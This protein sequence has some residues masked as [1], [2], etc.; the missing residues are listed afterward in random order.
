ME[1]STRSFLNVL[2][3]HHVAEIIIDDD[4]GTQSYVCKIDKIRST[5]KDDRLYKFVKPLKSLK[6]D[7]L[8]MSDSIEW[9]GVANAVEVYK[10]PS[11]MMWPTMYCSKQKKVSFIFSEFL[12]RRMNNLHRHR[13]IATMN[14]LWY[15]PEKINLFSDEKVVWAGSPGCGKTIAV[16][17]IIL[18]CVI[19][20]NEIG[21]ENK[22]TT[23]NQF[24][25][26]NNDFLTRFYYDL[27]GNKVDF[28]ILSF[29]SLHKLKKYL[30][31]EFAFNRNSFVLYEMDEAEVDPMIEMPFLLSTSC[32]NLRETIKTTWKSQN[33]FYLYDPMLYFEFEFFV[34]VSSAFGDR[35]PRA[36]ITDLLARFPLS[37]GIIRNIFDPVFTSPVSA[38]FE[39][40]AKHLTVFTLLDDCNP[41]NIIPLV[42]SIVGVKFRLPLQPVDEDE[43]FLAFKL[44]SLYNSSFY[45]IDSALFEFC[46]FRKNWHVQYLSDEIAIEIGKKLCLPSE[47]QYSNS[48]ALYQVQEIINI[49]G[50]ILKKSNKNI[51]LPDS[52]YMKNWEF[53]SCSMVPSSKNLI[54]SHKSVKIELSSAFLRS[55]NNYLISMMPTTTKI[56]TFQGQYL[57]TPFKKLQPSYVY[58]ASVHN[59]PVFDALTA[60]PVAGR[61]FLF[62][63]TL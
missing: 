33:T 36:T 20:L 21:K 50:G 18:D 57:Q 37:G 35:L 45:P 10:L 4:Y 63:S 11:S 16:N 43:D 47:I 60:D 26:R 34:N 27:K 6:A 14:R 15:A 59:G 58:H 30:N 29:E 5:L 9:A 19:K 39:N 1:S 53:F 12:I 55:D 54:Y 31:N 7:E 8:P 42:N 38:V 2:L 3:A 28:E 46:H 62:Q 48:S 44:S 51:N 32:R 52:F 13:V 25:F 61:L 49:Y 56:L 24:F 41:I 17:E 40:N 23:K 22:T